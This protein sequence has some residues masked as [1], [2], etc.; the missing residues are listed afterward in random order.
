[1]VTTAVPLDDERLERVRQRIV[2]VTG[3]SQVE[4]ETRVDPAI[5]GGITIRIGDQLLDGSTRARLQELRS[6]LERAAS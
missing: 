2:T 3:R 1:V 4:L 6:S 5:M